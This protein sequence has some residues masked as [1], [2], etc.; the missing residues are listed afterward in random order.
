MA[1]TADARMARPTSSASELGSSLAD[2]ARRRRNLVIRSG[3][4][5]RALTFEGTRCT[6]VRYTV[7]SAERAARAGRETIVS[8]GSINSPQL[9]ELSGIGNPDI[10]RDRGIDVVHALNGVGENLRDHYAPRFKWSVPRRLGLTYNVH[11]LPSVVTG[12]TR[13]AG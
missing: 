4:L 9:L 2:P 5:A 8:A 7:N 10:L 1:S 6:G 12:T 13:W 3:A 11:G